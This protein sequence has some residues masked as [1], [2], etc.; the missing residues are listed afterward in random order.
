MMRATSVCTTARC[1]VP[2]GLDSIDR[3]KLL[4]LDLLVAF[5]GDAIEHRGFGEM[6]DQPL[7][8]ALDR[9][10]VEQ[11]GCRATP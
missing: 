8:G 11:A 9:H 6:H 10:L 7:A 3:V 1:S 4:V 5:E 2:R